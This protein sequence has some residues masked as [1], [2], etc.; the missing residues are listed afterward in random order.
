MF[1][2]CDTLNVGE[3]S[4]ARNVMTGSVG[5]RRIYAFDFSHSTRRSKERPMWRLSAVVLRCEAPFPKTFVIP[6]GLLDG[7]RAGSGIEGLSL[8][9]ADFNRLYY[10]GSIDR[11]FASSVIHPQMMEF[12]I[13]NPGWSLELNGPDV[14]VYGEALWPIEKFPAAIEFLAGFLDRVPR[15]VWKELREQNEATCQRPRG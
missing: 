15:F 12:L 5:S 7:L 1:Q 6:R 9:S 10:V 3:P 4:S 11:H 14:V 2:T 13:A 8:E